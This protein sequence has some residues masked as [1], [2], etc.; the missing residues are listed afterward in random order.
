MPFFF[1]NLF[2]R[3]V[4]GFFVRPVCNGR[5][6]QYFVDVGE[7][8]SWGV[9]LVDWVS[10]YRVWELHTVYRCSRAID[11]VFFTYFPKEVGAE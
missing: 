6:L 3:I 4:P 11:G 8:Y 10:I 1:F 7:P 2:R 5:L 9:E